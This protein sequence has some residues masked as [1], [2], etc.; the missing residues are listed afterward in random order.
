MSEQHWKS[1]NQTIQAAVK[2]YKKTTS[3]PKFH[4]FLVSKIQVPN[5]P[6]PQTPAVLP[7]PKDGSHSTSLVTPHFLHNCWSVDNKLTFKNSMPLS[8]STQANSDPLFPLEVGWESQWPVTPILNYTLLLR[9]KL[10]PISRPRFHLWD[11]SIRAPACRL[12][13]KMSPG[14]HHTTH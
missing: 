5:K 8:A 12:E 1:T 4:D 11:L 9:K 14:S 7:S 13:R 6:L 10:T 2:R 3:P